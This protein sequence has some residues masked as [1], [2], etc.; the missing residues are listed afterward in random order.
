MHNILHSN[1]RPLIIIICFFFKLIYYF[2]IF[3]SLLKLILRMI[4][5]VYNLDY[6]HAPLSLMKWIFSFPRV[7]VSAANRCFRYSIQFRDEN[8]W[9][10]KNLPHFFW[11][12]KLRSLYRYV[13]FTVL[14][15][16]V[17]RNVCSEWVRGFQLRNRIFKF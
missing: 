5:L 10:V 16:Y 15:W 3:M 2:N 8:I 1:I 7:S 12:T 17:K 11:S 9:L 13:C 6:T 14:W 4:A